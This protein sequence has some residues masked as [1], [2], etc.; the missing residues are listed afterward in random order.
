M[1]IAEIYAQLMPNASPLERKA[2]I[3]A[4]IAAEARHCYAFAP[5]VELM[6]NARASWTWR[7][8]QG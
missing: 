5:T 4:E 1:A 7:R 6:R 2:A 3:A 8:M